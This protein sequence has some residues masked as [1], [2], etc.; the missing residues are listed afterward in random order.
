MRSSRTRDLPPRT[1]VLGKG[2]GQEIQRR[3]G[4]KGGRLREKRECGRQANAEVKITQDFLDYGKGANK[5]TL[6]TCSA[7]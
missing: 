7:F 4:E 3:S 1:L 2:G 5:S 6:K